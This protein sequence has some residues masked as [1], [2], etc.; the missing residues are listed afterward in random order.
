M[1]KYL[2]DLEIRDPRSR[3][4]ALFRRLPKLALAEQPRYRNTYHFH[5]LE[6]LR[7]TF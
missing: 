6:A 3:E 5:G 4:R 1:S 2:D 7:V